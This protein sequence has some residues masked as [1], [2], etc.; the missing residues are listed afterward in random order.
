MKTYIIKALSVLLVLATFFS[1]MSICLVS[2]SASTPKVKTT[3]SVRLRSS[4]LITSDNVI[5]TLGINEELT[6]LSNSSN[7]WAYVSRQD[8]TKGFCS[9]DYL[10]VVST[11]L[12]DFVGKTT[13]D[14]NFRKGPSTD[15]DSITVLA[16][17]TSFTVLDNSSELWV[18]A[19][20]QGS[21]GYIYRAYTSLELKIKETEFTQADD[22]DTPDWFDSSALDSVAGSENRVEEPVL[23]ADIALSTNEISIEQGSKF[24]LSAFVT[25]GG[26]VQSAVTFT[27]SDKNVATVTNGGVIKGV[28][29][30]T[31]TVTASL[32]GSGK[33]A[34][35]KVTVY[36]SVTEPAEE[37]LV[38]SASSLT[39]PMGNYGH[40]K[41]NLKVTWKSSDTSIA[42][43]S[44]GI[45]SAKAKGTATITASTSQQSVKCTVKVTSAS[46]G[47][48]I[49]KT[50]ATVTEGKTYYN[51]ASSSN[52]V[53]W[54]SS[55][56]NVATVKN[57]FI[58]AVSVGKAV[59]TAKNS[60]GEKT[61]LVTVKEAE[62][63]RFAYNEPNTAKIGETVTLYAVTDTERK[64]VRFDI[65]VGSQT[66]TVGADSKTSDSG[67]YVW[68]AKTT[69]SSAGT[70]TATAYAKGMDDKWSTCSAGCSDAVTSI[71]VRESADLKAET[72][73]TR[74]ASDDV[75]E[76]ISKF[77][78][79]SPSVYIDTIANNIP[80]L[81][82]GK[83]VYIGD[84]FYNYMTK[85]EAYAYL[86]QAVNNDGYT[87]AVNNYLNKY[88]ISR[89]QQQFD[90]LVSFAYNLGAYV[91][92]GDTDFRD[93]FLATGKTETVKP[94]DTDAYINATNVN[95]RKEPSTSCD[96]L[97]SLDYGA[98][99]TLVEKEPK[100]NW[101]HVKTVSGIEGYVYADYVTK[102]TLTTTSNPTGCSLGKVNKSDFTK[103][104]LQYH[105]AG[106]SCVYGLLYRRVDEL[107]VFYYGEYTRNGSENIYGYKFTCSV[108][109]STS[110]S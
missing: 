26:S 5:T 50:T 27:S 30:G 70:F 79:Y 48:S 91:F 42:T 19:S 61:C 46:T 34:A 60:L 84:S 90:S 106:A 78:G 24:I 82:Y 37:K 4:A 49:E 39:L 75:I 85:R 23:S 107:D 99:L 21:S 25:G 64:A 57:G 80:T 53:S 17:G 16:T 98:K 51:G 110:I 108:N 74:R 58:T 89:N 63:V 86:V 81:G 55:D 83:V 8:G 44:D 2:V 14:V 93:I 10:F 88:S 59:V 20:A 100:N 7:G 92:D 40:L 105:H 15:Y 28:S 104:L 9:V 73:E 12:I 6:L 97:A 62:P 33:T 45:I 95:L 41:A 77:E 13:D 101:Y 43:V 109:T 22:P 31:A 56:E 66:V 102:G 65:K 32:S 94:S 96:V 52:S 67:T 29:V 38:L 35:C 1:L 47:V 11:S 87:D 103:L 68:T 69:L 76:L 18:K 71:F 3:D 54:T 36:E 72:L